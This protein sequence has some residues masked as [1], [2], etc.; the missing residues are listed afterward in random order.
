MVAAKY[1][2][3]CS[4]A[5]RH[6]VQQEWNDLWH[7][8]ES[9]KLKIGFG[10]RSLLK[11]AE[12]HPELKE[13]LKV[14]DIDHPDSGPF[15]VY[16]LRILLS[17]DTIILL[18]DDPEGLEAALDHMANRWSTRK[19]VTFEH[20]KDFAHILNEGLSQVAEEYDPMAWKACFSGIFR[21]ITSRLPSS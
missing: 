9:A 4:A 1:E 7:D 10:R 14:V 18:L 13:I 3:C 19:G 6:I 5:D 20:F 2:H 16:S 21:K 8:V 17:F 15:E 12:D 11:L